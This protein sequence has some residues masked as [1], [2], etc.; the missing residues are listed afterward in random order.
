MNTDVLRYCLDISHYRNF[1]KAAE[2][3]H[4]SQQALS[5]QIKALEDELGLKLFARGKR[6]VETTPIGANFIAET[7]EALK[8]IDTAMNY[9]KAYRNGKN[10][11][12]SIG[13]NGPSPWKKL[14]KVLQTFIKDN[15]ETQIIPRNGIYDDIYAGF[16]NGDFDV[17][18]VGDFDNFD[19]NLYNI[20]QINTGP[21]QAVF[22]ID[23]PL[24]KKEFVTREELLKEQLLCIDVQDN[25]TFTKKRMERFQKILGT[26]PTKVRFVKDSNSID[27]LV[28]IGAGYTFLNAELAE[29][30]NPESLVFIPIKDVNICNILWLIWRKDSVNPALEKFLEY[31]REIS[32]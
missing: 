18:L 24:A 21:I 26:Q 3:N 17:I 12:L 28:A 7:S 20:R 10:Q 4:I 8:H 2:K 15:P 16:V 11:I 14:T 31:A 29:K 27:L 1:T 25:P 19:T 22:G 13:C 6:Y 23:H 9:V 32:V 30:H 5:Q